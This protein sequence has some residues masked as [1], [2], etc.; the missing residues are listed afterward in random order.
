MHSIQ[1]LSPWLNYSQEMQLIPTQ[2]PLQL[3]R[4]MSI[5]LSL[6]TR[7]DHWQTP[8]IVT[9]FAS[10]PGESVPSTVPIL[11]HSILI[12][13][14]NMGTVPTFGNRVV[15]VLGNH[16]YYNNKSS[17]KKTAA[18]S[19]CTLWVKKWTLFI[20]IYLWQILSDFN[21][22]FTVAHIN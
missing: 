7:L 18:N 15:P 6:M 22:S 10:D 20:W 2:L 21:N 8:N 5:Q 4:L 19:H 14:H 1:T 13:W 16:Q 9:L 3:D 11:C 12:L 17:S